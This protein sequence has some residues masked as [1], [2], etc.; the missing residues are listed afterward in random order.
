MRVEV[1]ELRRRGVRVVVVHGGAA[2][3]EELAEHF[4]ASMA[5]P[6]LF[7]RLPGRAAV[8]QL[9]ALRDFV[10]RH[11]V[12]LAHFHL[13]H[14]LL[15]L[16]WGSRAL[17]TIATCH[18]PV[19]PNGA[20]YW[21]ADEIVCH[22]QVGIGCVTVG[23]RRHGCATTA[24]GRRF[25]V[26]GLT[27]SL[28]ETRLSLA[29]LRRC[30]AVCAPSAWQRDRLVADGLAP[31]RVR[32]VAPPIRASAVART[33]PPGSHVKTVAV[34]GRLLPLKGVH[35][36]LRAAAALDDPPNVVIA[37]DGPARPALERLAQD[38]GIGRRVRWAGPLDHAATL[39]LFTEVDAVVVPS[40]WPETFGMVGAEALACG[41][42][43]VAYD[44][45]GIREWAL[46]EDGA[47]LLRPRD[48]RGLAEALSRV[49]RA[50][51][52]KGGAAVR[53]RFSVEGH[54]AVTLDLYGEV[55]AGGSSSRR[56]RDDAGG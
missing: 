24:D 44:A 40:L 17:P 16:A 22:R 3:E 20:R 55:L 43:V 41:T 25:S 56:P 21:H 26:L 8:Q 36:V 32:V 13:W 46:P 28:L 31:E 7:R 47:V 52:P 6:A 5:A 2:S 48:E 14:G 33:R 18:L 10:Q 42:P 49:L 4:D 38:L 27:L 19:C 51:L 23:A 30:S 12:A 15:L 35:H 45:G 54:A 11:G 29:L 37:G 34:A 39:E 50:Q 53:R 1:E 9:W